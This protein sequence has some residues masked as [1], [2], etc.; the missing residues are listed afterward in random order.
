[1]WL[2]LEPMS[3][4]DARR[5]GKHLLMK[6]K[7]ATVELYP[8][9]DELRTGPGSLVRL[10]L[11]VHRKSRRRYPFVSSSG[12]PLAS[13]AREQLH[14]LATPNRISRAALVPFVGALQELQPVAPTAKDTRPKQVKGET[15]SAR[16]KNA[17]SV[18]DFV[19]QYVALDEAGRRFCP[20]HDDHRQSFSVSQD[21]N[22][23]HCF[24][25]CGGGSII[26]FWMKWREKLGQD[27]TFL[28][29]I[30]ELARMLL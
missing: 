22:Y 9:Q 24:A 3:G 14:I 16:I 27:A 18:Y 4:K 28:A 2:F 29:T 30:T 12:T 11:G 15:P 7:L 1:L 8:K 23:W 19:G 6:H 5:F 25:G 20:F 17:I 10:L 26:D 21:G 13:T